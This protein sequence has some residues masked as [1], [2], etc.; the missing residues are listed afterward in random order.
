MVNAALIRRNS[1]FGIQKLVIKL[2]GIV[3]IAITVI[4]IATVVGCVPENMDG[5][6]QK[7]TALAVKNNVD[8]SREDNRQ[9]NSIALVVPEI[10]DMPAVQSLKD[11][12]ATPLP[13]AETNSEAM[14]RVVGARA[15][16]RVKVIL[17]QAELNEKV[18]RAQEEKWRILVWV[19][20]VGAVIIGSLALLV[21]SPLDKGRR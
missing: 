11:A 12:T 14:V 15:D 3:A 20:G 19:V 21:R 7:Q 2:V 18:I 6:S 13:S 8:L 1:M 5:L 10:S 9:D 16:E 17:A 4:C